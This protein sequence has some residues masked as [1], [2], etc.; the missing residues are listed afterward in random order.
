MSD[1][2]TLTLTIQG[3]QFT[4]RAPYRTGHVCTPIEAAVLNQCRG[5][6]LRNNFA[7]TVKQYLNGTP[8]GLDKVTE[9][10]L[11]EKFAEYDA[12]YSFATPPATDPVETE[13]RRIAA[14]LVREEFNKR[15]MD[16]KE[17]HDKFTA[18]VARASVLPSVVAEAQRRVAAKRE[19]AAATGL[20]IDG[21]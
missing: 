19:A 9:G 18:S 7:K 14:A 21:A 1:Q 16:A 12:A 4:A 8:L 5:D 20:I 15:G 6:N 3:I 11:R 2:P 17:L 10:A 13:A